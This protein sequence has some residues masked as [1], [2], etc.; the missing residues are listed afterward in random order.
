M[1][2]R[3]DYP[4]VGSH[5]IVTFPMAKVLQ[6]RLNRPEAL[7][8]M[9][10]ELENDIRKVMDWFEQEPSLWV[11][12]ITGTGRS[13]C[14]GQDL[15]NWNQTAG[16]NDS[17]T[18]KIKSNPFGFGSLARRTS[19]KVLIA[20]CNGM[21]F[22][23]GVE[24]LLNC[25]IVIG[26][27]GAKLGLPEVKRGVVASVGGIPNL[28]TKCPAL[29]PYVL[30]GEPMPQHLLIGSVLTE[31]VHAD[32]VVSTALGWASKVI[33]CSP[34]AVQVTKQQI[35]LHKDGLGIHQVV[36]KSL[37]TELAQ[38]LYSGQNLKEGLKAFVEKRPPQWQDP[39]RLSKL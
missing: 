26:C 22:G 34:D 38:R 13:F 21:A 1:S 30:T 3:T 11:V 17:P 23:G 33:S 9:T 27:Q 14:A 8:A 5:L 12:V 18:H 4:S 39:P 28:V 20:A 35:N 6:L 29:I 7:N 16:T 36:Y 15:K 10:D 24:L 19:N 32:K 25:D 37:E 31:V 2:S